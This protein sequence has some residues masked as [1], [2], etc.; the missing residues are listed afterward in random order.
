MKSEAFI[1]VNKTD[2]KKE[3][4]DVAG[5]IKSKSGN[6][7]YVPMSF[8]DIM[9]E[10]KATVSLKPLHIREA[11]LPLT[12]VACSLVSFRLPWYGHLTPWF[13]R[14]VL[15]HSQEAR[16]FLFFVFSRFDQFF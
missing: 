5:A 15:R 8:P 7:V 11:I 13:L 16:Q 9:K 12:V 3:E 14:R 4:E 10:Q 2:S 6:K 1:F